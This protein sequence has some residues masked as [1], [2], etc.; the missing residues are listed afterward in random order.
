M[1]DIVTAFWRRL[2]VPGK[3]AASVRR[4]DTGFELFGQSVFLDPRGPTAL[5]YVL[6]L[7]ESWATRS[8]HISGFVGKEAIETR[9]YRG[10]KGWTLNGRPFGMG[11]VLDLDLGFTPA[12]NMVQLKRAALSVGEAVDFDV[13]WLEAGDQE[14]VRLPQEYKRVS[15]LDYWYRSPTADYEGKIKLSPSGFATDYPELWELESGQN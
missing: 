4:T 2:D 13:A 7:E 8:G 11:D 5:R 10:T 9:I 1:S 12:T 3:D 6:D 14:L 15:E